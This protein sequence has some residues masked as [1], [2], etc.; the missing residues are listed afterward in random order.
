MSRFG[1][2][3]LAACLVSLAAGCRSPV[4]P[5]LTPLGVDDPRPAAL[6]AALDRHAAAVRGVRGTARVAIEGQRGASF[7]RQLVLLERPDRMRV[8]VLGLLNQRVA[9]LATDGTAYQLYRAETGAVERGAVHPQV[10]SEVAGLPL[11]PGEAVAVLLGGPDPPT[12]ALRAGALADGG[13]QLE[14]TDAG[15]GL[16]RSL[17]FD[18][19]GNL[20]RYRVSPPDGAVLVDVAYRDFASVGGTDFAHTIALDFPA[21]DTRA[22]VTFRNVEIN[23]PLPTGLFTLGG[24]RQSGDGVD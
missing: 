3:A 2:L 9:V 19:A 16:R 24:G 7:A 22:E 23:P 18:P 8:E 13:V 11:T 21:S 12:G 4:P 14:L 1:R 17:D 6:L 5:A 15:S 20:R 10:L